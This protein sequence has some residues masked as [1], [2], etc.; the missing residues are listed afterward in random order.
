M[1]KQNNIAIGELV[2]QKFYESDLT[3][4][5]FADKINCSR[6]NVYSIFKRKKIDNERLI[7]ISKA[8]NYN[9]LSII[10]NK[11]TC[12]AQNYLIVISLA[13]NE[14][15]KFV[16]KYSPALCWQLS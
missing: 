6:T 13:E 5:E 3:I 15:E 14:Y 9:F 10:L 16:K 4:T 2:Q 7:M 11:N 12:F 8:L 1:Q